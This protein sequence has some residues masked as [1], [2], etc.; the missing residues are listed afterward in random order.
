MKIFGISRYFSEIQ[1]YINIFRNC[2][3][4][5]APFPEL[6]GFILRKFFMLKMYDSFAALVA[7]GTVFAMFC[8]G[9]S[10]RRASPARFCAARKA[11]R[12]S[13][14]FSFHESILAF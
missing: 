12:A 1:S 6:S 9:N 13:F 11:C 3:K 2:A 4:S 14:S 10:S 5:C 7:G 8:S